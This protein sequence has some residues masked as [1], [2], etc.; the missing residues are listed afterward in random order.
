L[1]TRFSGR[2]R[3]YVHRK[4]GDPA[5][6]SDHKHTP[7]PEK[8]KKE[9]KLTGKKGGKRVQTSQN[10]QPGSIAN[11]SPTTR[12]VLYEENDDKCAQRRISP[13]GPDRK[14]KGRLQRRTLTNKKLDQ[15]SHRNPNKKNAIFDEK[16]LKRS[17][18]QKEKK[19]SLPDSKRDRAS[20]PCEATP[21]KGGGRKRWTPLTFRREG[22]KVRA[23]FEDG[24]RNP[25]VLSRSPETGHGPLFRYMEV[26][27]QRRRGG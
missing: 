10:Q 9:V 20:G 24:N 2:K 14:G 15:S 17:W 19:G 11:R 12:I 8:K 16:E 3:F 26:S 7:T 6:L 1:S 27:L 21:R 23:G 5:K 4:R 22:K 25:R 13:T 18:A